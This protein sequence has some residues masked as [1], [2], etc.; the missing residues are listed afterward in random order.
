[1]RKETPCFNVRNLNNRNSK[2]K[3]RTGLTLTL[4]PASTHAKHKATRSLWGTSCM[5]LNTVRGR[6]KRRSKCKIN[7]ER[8]NRHVDCYSTVTHDSLTFL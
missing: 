2:I 3:L 7:N 1:M 4:S 5:D 6:G 8:F